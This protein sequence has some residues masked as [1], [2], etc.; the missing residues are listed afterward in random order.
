VGGTGAGTGGTGGGGGGNTCTVYPQQTEGPFYI[1]VD[2]LRRDITE[3][4]AGMPLSVVVKATRP[5]VL[6]LRLP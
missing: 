2:S 5:P 1:D 6:S 3:G 4:K